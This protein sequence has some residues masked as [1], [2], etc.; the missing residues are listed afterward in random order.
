MVSKF[1]V[2][3]QSDRLSMF[4]FGG[5]VQAVDEQDLQLQVMRAHYRL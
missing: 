2:L 1:I 3:T 4:T 5:N